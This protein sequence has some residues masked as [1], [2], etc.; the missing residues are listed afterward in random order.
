MFLR[1]VGVGWVDTT[2]YTMTCTVFLV[3]IICS[4]GAKGY[5]FGRQINGL[6]SI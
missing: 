1:G 5:T 4:L 6:V 2:M 3:C